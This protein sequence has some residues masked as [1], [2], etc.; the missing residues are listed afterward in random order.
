V[1][2]A[3]PQTEIK[4]PWECNLHLISGLLQATLTVQAVASIFR[5]LH[6]K[7]HHTAQKRRGLQHRTSSEHRAELIVFA[8]QAVEWSKCLAAGTP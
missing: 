1:H 7:G 8:E 5:W 3:S 2:R 4:F 6:R